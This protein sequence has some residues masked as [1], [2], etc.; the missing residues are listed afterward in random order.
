MTKMLV[1]DPEKRIELLDIMETEYY[2]LSDDEVEEIYERIKKEKQ[3]KED[4]IKKKKEEEQKLSTDFANQTYLSEPYSPLTIKTQGSKSPA[5]NKKQSSYPDYSS[6][7]MSKK[8]NKSG[9]SGQKH[10]G[11]IS[12]PKSSVNKKT[13]ST[14][15]SKNV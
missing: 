12:K 7:A 4:I 3:D 13:S 11:T 8:S 9:T 2:Q 10:A 5:R 14:G 1:K 6:G 15:G